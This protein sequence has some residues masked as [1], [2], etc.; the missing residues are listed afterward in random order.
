MATDLDHA[1]R[2]IRMVREVEAKALRN[3]CEEEGRRLSN[4]AAANIWNENNPH[5]GVGG[6]STNPFA[7]PSGRDARN[8][9]ECHNNLD[10]AQE[11]VD[12]TINRLLAEFSKTP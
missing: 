6:M 3:F 1:K 7:D 8:S 5:D 11:L 4:I 12:F 10:T 2:L 9:A